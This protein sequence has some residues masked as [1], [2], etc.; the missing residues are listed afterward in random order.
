MAANYAEASMHQT[1]LFA[2]S[3]K[4]LKNLRTQ[5]YSA[6]EYFELSFTNDNQK[7]MVIETL[8]DYA[9]KALVNTVDHLGS[10]SFKVNDLVE[11]KIGK[12]S[13]ADLRISCL[14]QR[15]RT[16]EIYMN[17]EGRSQQSSSVTDAPKYHKRYNLPAGETLNCATHAKSKYNE[18]KTDD[19]DQHQLKID[20]GMT[21]DDT[22]SPSLPIVVSNQCNPTPHAQTSQQRG[23]FL[24]NKPVQIADIVDKKTVGPHPLSLFR[25]GSLASR[26][27]S[28]NS[29]ISITPRISADR[30]QSAAEPRKSASMRFYADENSSP[31]ITQ[32]QRS[33]SK[34]LLKALLSKRRPKK[35]DILYTF[36]DEY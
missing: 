31:K 35:D 14:E 29:N 28:P 11:E 10:V 24:Y 16:C 21:L 25:S 32:H 15:L 7:H 3:L 23:S 17:N 2:D 36:L 9:I 33:M 34:R 5:L 22:P 13:K 19:G 6:A 1:L 4:D 12:A 20:L 27:T 18:S 8:K 30:R 26:S